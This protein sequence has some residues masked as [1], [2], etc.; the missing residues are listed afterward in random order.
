MV[1]L[2]A[3]VLFFAAADPVTHI[4][5][6]DVTAAL[7]KPVAPLTQG[8]KYSVLALRRTSAGQAEVHEKDTDVFY[9]ID[10]TATFT[11]GGAV[12]GGKNTAP[13]EIRGSAIR[14]G[15]SRRIAKGDVLTIPQGVPHWFSQVEG[16]VTYLVVKVR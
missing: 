6:A 12:V 8:E 9:V 4:P 1:S 16:S 5:A 13:G 14:D 7:G 2:M 3:L 10:G 11:T 15:Q